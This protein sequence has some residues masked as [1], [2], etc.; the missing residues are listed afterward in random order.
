MTEA[1]VEPFAKNIMETKMRLIST[2]YT[3]FTLEDAVAI[4]RAR[5]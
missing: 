3:D 1:D 5:L 2:A 4:F